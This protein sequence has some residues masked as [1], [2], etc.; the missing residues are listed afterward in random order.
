[1]DDLTSSPWQVG[2]FG[3]RPQNSQILLGQTFEDSEIERRAFSADGRIFCIASSGS[4]ALALC[5]QHDVVACDIN[6]AQLA[7]AARRVAGG[8]VERGATDRAIG[9]LRGL[10]PFAGWHQATLR[11]FLALSRTDEQVDFWQTTLDTWRFRTCFDAV[12]SLAGLRAIY[13]PAVIDVLPPHFGAVIRARMLRCFSRHPNAS[14]PYAR[15]L[16]LGE[17]EA[18]ETGAVEARRIQLVTSEA[19][20]YLEGCAPGRF[21]GFS[22]SN[23]LDGARPAF[24]DRLTRAVHRAAAPEAVVVARSYAEP[25]LDMPTNRAIDDRSM[26]WGS[27]EVCDAA[28]WN[29]P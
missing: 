25:P 21:V 17:S 28:A 10:M 19:A 4:M 26:I 27:V 14:N 22:L 11:A 8:K 1:M 9:A 15:K 16:L 13:A 24:R 12:L 18:S 5:G 29:A 20:A 2:R 6:P 3:A 23:I 7:Y